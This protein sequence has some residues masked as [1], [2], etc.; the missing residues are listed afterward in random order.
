MKKTI[1]I[2]A[3]TALASLSLYAQGTVSFVNATATRVFEP[4]GTTAVAG[5]RGYQ[6]ELVFAQDGTTD[7]E[8]EATATRLGA[9]AVIGTPVAGLFSGGTRTAPTATA[10]GF[11]R[12]QVRV[13]QTTAGNDWR[14]VIAAGRPNDFV[15]ESAILRIDTGD[16]TTIPPGTASGLTGLTAITLRPVPE[17]SVIG[18]GLLGAGALL[19][20]RRRK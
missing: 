10:G 19:L 5:T 11:G 12:F 16:P 7:A 2:S 1:V 15:G 6:A 8:F 3:L 20:L 18:L 4:N 13:W 17:P 14:S 9:A